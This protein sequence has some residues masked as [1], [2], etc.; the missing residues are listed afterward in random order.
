MEVIRSTGA[1]AL[2]VNSQLQVFKKEKQE[3]KPKLVKRFPYL[4]R[5]E[6]DS[7]KKS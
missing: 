7:R 2:K 4:S 5:Q 3:R 1:N 6:I